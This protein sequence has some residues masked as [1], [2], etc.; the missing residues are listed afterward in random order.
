MKTCS[1]LIINNINMI[2]QKRVA[3]ATLFQPRLPQSKKQTAA[4]LEVISPICNSHLRCKGSNYLRI[5]VL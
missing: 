5:L 4:E 1:K 2:E 3:I